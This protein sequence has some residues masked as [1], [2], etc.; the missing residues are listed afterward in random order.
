M[1]KSNTQRQREWRERQKDK[2]ED[3]FKE[4]ERNQKKR[5]YIP[6]S[7]LS[8]GAK[9]KRNEQKKEGMKRH[10]EKKKLEQQ[11]NEPLKIKMNFRH[12]GSIGCMKQQ[13]AEYRKELA[14]LKIQNKQLQ[15]QALKF[16]VIVSTFYSKS[17]CYVLSLI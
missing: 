17:R 16:Q 6:T 5:S 3:L 11:S 8:A 1:A 10:R 12:K 13:A 4:R 2:N 14:E 7:Q 9:K 15:K